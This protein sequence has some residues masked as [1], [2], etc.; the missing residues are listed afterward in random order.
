MVGVSLLT[1]ASPVAM[2]TAMI[3]GLL[4]PSS[5]ATRETT[6]TQSLGQIRSSGLGAPQHCGSNLAINLVLST[7]Q[8]ATPLADRYL[9]VAQALRSGIHH[10][11]EVDYRAATFMKLGV[12]SRVFK[13]IVMYS[14]SQG[15]Q[16]A[17]G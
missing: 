6:P 2:Q 8:S 16:R 14:G 11:G 13:N 3:L 5:T 7:V 12:E 10:H 9:S 17:M 4:L 1:P 15:V